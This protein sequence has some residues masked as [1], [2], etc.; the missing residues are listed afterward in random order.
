[1]SSDAGQID[2]G[3]GFAALNGNPAA[4]AFHKMQDGRVLPQ[5][6]QVRRSETALREATQPFFEERAPKA[7]P[8]ICI[9]DRQGYLGMTFADVIG[10]QHAP[11]GSVAFDLEQ[12]VRGR[13]VREAVERGR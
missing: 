1:M 5:T 9:L 12:K 11:H 6:V 13:F 4:C 3:P 7:E 10:F 8:L 2:F